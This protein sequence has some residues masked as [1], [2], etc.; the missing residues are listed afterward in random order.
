[1]PSQK[2]SPIKSRSRF[3]RNVAALRAAKGLTQENTAETIGVSTRYF[4]SV[5][6]GEYFPSFP[7]LL[8]LQ[9]VLHCEWNDLFSGCEPE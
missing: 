4:Q 2:P 9:K 5:E 8:R 7:T 6:A 1:M 3:G